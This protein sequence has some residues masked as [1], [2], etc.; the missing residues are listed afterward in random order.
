MPKMKAK[1]QHVLKH[2]IGHIILYLYSN[3]VIQLFCIKM[4]PRIM[5]NNL[6]NSKTLYTT[7]IINLCTNPI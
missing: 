7:Q 6:N 3:I 4:G 1:K 5:V 2:L